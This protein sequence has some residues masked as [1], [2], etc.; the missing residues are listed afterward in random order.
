MRIILVCGLLGLAVSS[1]AQEKYWVYF[2]DKAGVQLDVAAT[3]H[4]AAIERR[5]LNGV[6]FP[7]ISDLPVKAEYESLVFGLVDSVIYASR[8]LNAVYVR[9]SDI[10]IAEV[11]QLDF[12]QN[13]EKQRRMEVQ[14]CEMATPM[15][16]LEQLQA[17][18]MALMGGAHF[19]S[20]GLDGSG[21][22]IAIFDGGFPQV[23][24]HPVMEHIRSAGNIKATFN[25]SKPGKTIY[26]SNSHGLST[27]SNVGGIWDGK[28][29]GHATGATFLLAVTEINREIY[30]EE[31]WWLAA[32]EWADQNGAHIINSS[33]GYTSKRY[34][35]EQM[36]GSYSLVSRAATMASEKGILV[37]N[38]AGNEGDDKWTVIG[39]PADAP[40]VLSV[41]GVDPVTERKIGFSSYGPTAIGDRKPNVSAP[42]TTVAA[43]KG[44]KVGS[45][46][47][48]SFSS[49]LVAGFAACVMQQFPGITRAE[50]FEAIE[51]S[52]HLY[53]YYD[54]AHGYGIPQAH[55]ATNFDLEVAP[56]FQLKKQTGQLRLFVNADVPTNQRTN[57]FL[58][59]E[60][61]YFHLEDSDGKLLDYKVLDV[62]QEEVYSW[63]P[64]DLMHA[65][66]L[67]I[68]YRGYTKT[69]NLTD[70]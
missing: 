38:A 7:H 16:F 60:Y 43:I 5:I 41:A 32:A 69:I 67:R 52:G 42:A 26:S 18:Q 34:F 46:S 10:Q 35:P 45:V 36:D 3:F 31:V 50:L 1:F 37:V 24:T 4:P 59:Q 62:F 20:L 54:Y 22:R 23:N 63:I 27:M 65:A 9:A 6:P 15:G 48:T 47:G 30:K 66:K 64:E 14:L 61:L 29:L 13:V 21:I 44:R 68:H 33:L 55:L 17:R 40:M 58:G 51:K 57:R 8:W 2:K 25:F 56:T 53:P 39:A 70:L 11:A 49:P 19:D 12:V 28:K